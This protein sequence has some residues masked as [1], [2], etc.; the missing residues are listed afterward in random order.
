MKLFLLVGAGGCVGA[1]L[2][3][4]ISL[5]MGRWVTPDRLPLGTLL[6]NVLG[7]LLIGALLQWVGAREDMRHLV[8]IGVLGGLTTFSTFSLETITMFQG[9]RV[10]QGLL[11]AGLSFG[12]CMGA[13]VLGMLMSRV[14]VKVGA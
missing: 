4:A 9:Q 7:C 2:R 12:L 3:Y 11:Y 10:L 8:I 14:F 1:M 6:A 13:V 5:G